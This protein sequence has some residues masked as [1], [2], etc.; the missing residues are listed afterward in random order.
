MTGGF[1]ADK[2]P[3]SFREG[4]FCAPVAAVASTFVPS[5]HT[6]C[7]PIFG[8][9]VAYGSTVQGLIST[10][11]ARCMRNQLLIDDKDSKPWW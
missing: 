9:L 11:N 3:V 1:I 2:K 5:C 7:F 4:R 6:G 8:Q 10:I